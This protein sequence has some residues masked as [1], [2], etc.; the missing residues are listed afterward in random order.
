M[1]MYSKF[2]MMSLMLGGIGSNNH[3][4]YSDEGLTE[5]EKYMKRI[6]IMKSKG[7]KQFFIEGTEIWAR[8]EKN[9]IRK[10]NNLKK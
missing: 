4:T 3:G 9:A 7:M 8:N 2:L 10:F 6:D 5:H 1:N